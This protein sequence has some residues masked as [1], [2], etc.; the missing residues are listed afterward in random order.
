MKSDRWFVSL[1]VLAGSLIFFIGYRFT[2][3]YIGSAKGLAFELQSPM[4]SLYTWKISSVA[5]FKYRQ[6]FQQTV[7]AS[8][9]IVRARPDDNDSF[10]RMYRGWSFF[11]FIASI[12]S[13]YGFL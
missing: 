11:L 2:G 9:R 12:L 10:I 13:F 5:P 1:L 8:W 3:A 7:L 4:D 6:L